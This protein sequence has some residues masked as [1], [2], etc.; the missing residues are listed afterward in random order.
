[1]CNGCFSHVHCSPSRVQPNYPQEPEDSTTL[2]GLCN[3][4][5]LLRCDLQ[6]AAEIG[7]RGIT[8]EFSHQSYAHRRQDSGKC[9]H[10]EFVHCE[11]KSTIH[12]K[13]G[14]F[15]TFIFT[16]SLSSVLVS[17]KICDQL[18]SSFQSVSTKGK[19]LPAD[20]MEFCQIAFQP[21]KQ[22]D[23][24]WQLFAGILSIL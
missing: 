19:H 13:Y 16:F 9:R 7:T 8:L 15:I 3:S 21:P 11:A 18:Y 20:Q 22:T 12:I 6:K 5:L 23:P 10:F 24:L 1:M 2:P 14:K 17:Q 4:I